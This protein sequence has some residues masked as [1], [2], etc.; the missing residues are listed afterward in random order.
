MSFIVQI[1]FLQNLLFNGK[2]ILKNKCLH[3]A[4]DTVKNQNDTVNDTVF[5]KIIKKF[6]CRTPH[7]QD[8]ISKDKIRALYK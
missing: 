5:E 8:I 1:K 2:N 4:N 7:Y 3:F 6:L